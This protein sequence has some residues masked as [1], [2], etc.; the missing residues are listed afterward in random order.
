MRILR[1]RIEQITKFPLSHSYNDEA[2]KLPPLSPM[3]SLA[4]I[5]ING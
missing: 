3:V 4:C 5:A 2:P 1:E